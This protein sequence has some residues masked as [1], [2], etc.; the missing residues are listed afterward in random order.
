[1]GPS[2]SPFPYEYAS[3]RDLAYQVE[4]VGVQ[5]IWSA[6][7]DARRILTQRKAAVEKL[8]ARL[9]AAGELR[10]AA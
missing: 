8:G 1:M 7:R 5:G 2:F 6:R 4:R 3:C 9:Y 10:F